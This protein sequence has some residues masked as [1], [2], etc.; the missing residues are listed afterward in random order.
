MPGGS[1]R[2]ATRGGP[3]KI[4]GNAL[5]PASLGGTDVF[6]Q[7]FVL[8][9][10]DP[11]RSQTLTERGEIRPWSAFLA[12]VKLALE[13]ERPGR[14]AGLRFLTASV[15][16]PTL[17]AQ[18]D[19][20]LR[21]FPEAKWVAWE[22]I[23]RDNV[24]EGAR[25]AFGES[26]EPQYAFAKADVVLSLEMDFLGE[27]PAQP[28]WV[29]D[30]ASRRRAEN[31]NRSVR[32]RVDA[33]ADRRPGGP[34]TA[35]RPGADRGLRPRR[36][37]GR[38]RAARGDRRRIPS[39][40][41]SRRTSR[42]TGAPGSSSPAPS[43]PPAV[44]ALAHAMNQALGNAGRTVVYTEPVLAKP[45]AQAAALAELARD[46]RE[47]RVSTLVIVGGNPAFT[48][49]ADLRFAEAMEKV[50]LR[51]RLSL[52][53]D[54]TSRLCHWQV[55]E[56]H[57]LEAWS[58]ARAFDGTATILQPL[59]LPLYG[60]K[61]GHE[62]LAAFTEQPE[63]SG[64]DIV[65]DYWREKMPG[66]DFE[67]AWRKAVHDGVVEGTA[68]AEKSVAVRAPAPAAAAAPGA[69]RRAHGPVP[70]GPDR[71]GRR[72]RQQRL[73]AGAL[74][75]PDEADLGQRRADRALDRRKA[76]RDDG[77]HGRALPRR[78]QGHRARLG[79]AGAGRGLRHAARRLRAH[80][81][82]TR[83][84]R[85]GLRR[86]SP[87][88]E[89]RALVAPGPRGP[90]DRRPL[91][92]RDDPAPLRH[93]R[94][95]PRARRHG[96]AVPRRP[97]RRPEDGRA[98]AGPGGHALSEAADGELR[99]GALDRSR[100]LRR[101]QR[102]C[103]GLPVGE[104][105]P[106]RRQ[107]RGRARARPSVDP[108]R[109]LLLGRARKPR[110]P[111]PAGHLH[112]LRERAV[113]GRLSGQRHGAQRRGPEPDGLQPVRGHAVL[114]EQL[115]LQ[116]AALQLLPLRG[117]QERPLED[118]SQP[119][120]HGAQPRRHGEVQLLRPEDQPGAHHGGEG[121]PPD[122]RRRDRDGVPA[123]LPR[124]GDRIREHRRPRKPRL[125]GA[126]R[127]AAVRA[128]GRARNAAAHD[129]PGL[130][131]ESEPGPAGP[132]GREKEHGA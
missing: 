84:E 65:Q 127:E 47:G 22:P 74:Q 11:D 53:D 121:E 41:R 86:L 89:R 118:G 102:L 106:R 104:Q 33:H 28:R 60:G 31:T 62:I 14:G 72:L 29:R 26:A 40:H 94:A 6:A 105:H 10:Y 54:E 12:A 49:P 99:L 68:F 45:Q 61:S 16:S 122:P 21:A 114:L 98:P 70:A 1:S 107:A 8:D 5:H 34:P 71:L 52:H 67:A 55:P 4:E 93:G 9:L 39:P 36:R 88:L 75:A 83:R 59:I 17:I 44:H 24:Y 131:V 69:R 35:A 77:R 112:A 108:D 19:G 50:A 115:P 79:D 18:M 129:L 7:A 3:T 42:R 2:R 90:K 82:R 25:L 95:R 15:S 78:A 57:A 46:M 92:A 80:A 96:R 100:L 43:Q 130:A 109:P 125:A 119:R 58:D 27:G 116:G 103:R 63:K 120:G 87:A 85:Q 51:V 126:G 56:A 30:F 101:V 81:R 13:K 32:R 73:A 20:I 66:A 76:R 110:D 91:P 117:L 37:F 97:R 23:G 38:R 124:A 123:G 64:H 128:P 111:P 132:R 48:A 113:R